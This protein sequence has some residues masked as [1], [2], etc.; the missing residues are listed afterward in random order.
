[1]Q[2]FKILLY[3][4]SIKILQQSVIMIQNASNYRDILR[5]ISIARRGGARRNFDRVVIESR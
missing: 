3:T 5:S 4:N 1:M 2:V